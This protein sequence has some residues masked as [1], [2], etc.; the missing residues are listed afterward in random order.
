MR[1]G[2]Q[3]LMVFLMLWAIAGMS[4]A[5]TISNEP[6]IPL[7]LDDYL[8]QA[9]MNN[10]GLRAAFESW[11]AAMEQIPQA[12]ALDD[13]RF[14]YGYFLQE[15]E[16]RV[17]PQKHRLGLTQM[18]PWFGKLDVRTDAAAAEAKAAHH[19]Y[20]AVKVK[21]FYQTSSVFYEFAYLAK[22]VDIAK[23]NLE[24][25]KHFEQV[26]RE[27]YRTAEGSHPDIVRAQ[28]ELATMEDDLI[29]MTQMRRPVVAQL[30]AVMNRSTDRDLPWPKQEEFIPVEINTQA[31]VEQIHSANPELSAMAQQVLASRRMAELAGKR[32]WPDVTLGVDWIVTDQARMP[33]VYGSGR[34]AVVAM[35]SINLPIWTDSY[36]AGVK[37][38]N[39]MTA[40]AQREKRQA[41]FDL[42]AQAEQV[43]FELD[44]NL[45]KIRLY[46]N[47]LIPKAKEMID[48]SE[49]AYRTNMIDFL[50]LLDAQKKLLGFQLKHQRVLA[51]YLQKQA[52]LEMLTGQ[53]LMDTKGQ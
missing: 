9:A 44:D 2:G 45:R 14:T 36:S 41:E 10:S 42:V 53:R 27:K 3:K 25:M 40:M 24:L 18:F 21:L 5:Q 51:N 23:D 38:A 33:N 50:S 35:I 43:M 28:I 8:Y 12:A 31:I 32:Y 13:P 22:A 16:T 46:E 34:D 19:S 11:R 26:A 37:Q 29:S 47:V 52:E 39:A 48:V 30:N 49:Q 15:V 4:F 1:Q 17:G 20:E 6:N 7:V